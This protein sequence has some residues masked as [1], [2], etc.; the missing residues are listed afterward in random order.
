MKK[1][2][3]SQLELVFRKLKVK[4]NAT[5][6]K[7]DFEKDFSLKEECSRLQTKLMQIQVE[8]LYIDKISDTDFV[9]LCVFFFL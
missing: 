9:C 5:L 4:I 3:P 1:V 8:C 6:S 2:Q 7:S